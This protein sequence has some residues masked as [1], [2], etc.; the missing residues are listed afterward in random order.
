MRLLRGFLYDSGYD[1]NKQVCH[2]KIQMFE[3]CSEWTVSPHRDLKEEKLK[4][5]LGFKGNV[6]EWNDIIMR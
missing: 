4:T 6:Y 5:A 2:T 1:G 3:L